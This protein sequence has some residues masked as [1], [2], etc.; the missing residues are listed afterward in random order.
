MTHP[1]FA[2]LAEAQELIDPMTNLDDM[3]E[4]FG[5]MPQRSD[6]DKAIGQRVQVIMALRDRIKFLET[7][8]DGLRSNGLD[9]SREFNAIEDCKAVLDSMDAAYY[10][11]A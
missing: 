11:E 1:E 7:V 5:G 6:L 3:P 4:E 9:C 2:Q 8:A 10:E